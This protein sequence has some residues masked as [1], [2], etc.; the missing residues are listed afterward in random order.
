MMLTTE[1]R[2]R[3]LRPLLCLALAGLLAWAIP[4]TAS[5]PAP[6]P[7]PAPLLYVRFVTPFGGQVT[8][9]AGAPAGRRFD[10]PVTVGLR[11]GYIYR[12]QL[13][14]LPDRP[15]LALY[16]S[17]E[18]RGTLCLPATLRP[19]DYPA[20]IPISDQDI[21]LCLAGGVITKVIYLEDPAHALAVATQPNQPLETTLR[22]GADPAD[23]ARAFGRPM[24]IVRLGARTFSP[25]EMAHQSIPGTILL[26]GDAGL[27]APA[28][29]PCLPWAGVQLYD[30]I[31]GPRH[32]DDECLHDGGDSGAPAGLDQEGHLH[33]LDPSDTVAEYTDNHG[34]KHLAISNRVC[35][36]VPR[37]AILAV[38]LAPAGTVSSLAPARA[39]TVLA[40]EL[41]R[42]KQ[43]EIELRQAEKLVT[44][45]GRE[46]A[47]G[48][49]S[50]IGALPL[51]QSQGQAV[52]MGVLHEEVVIGTLEKKVCPPP[53][54][55]LVLCKTA[56]K[57]GVQVG[58][59][60]TFTLQFTNSGGQPIT[61]VVVS[62][63]LTGRLEYVPGSAQT[64]RPAIFTTQDNE[65]GSR[66][67]RWEIGGRLLPGESGVVRFQARVR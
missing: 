28:V 15:G 20:P 30:P 48:M 16:P 3:S 51:L 61:G 11:P 9:Y 60:V 31:L 29:R 14:R 33:G 5:L 4:A 49:E 26:P 41:L 57:Q 23:E 67:L 34:Q 44:L 18:V 19:A 59:V 42:V 21:A 65:A 36:C 12:V 62:D 47:S 8:V 32:C 37:F 40:Q 38:P 56:D 7:V 24:L 50:T 2:T 43:A 55:P 39:E 54:R 64:D 13:D 45:R 27:G 6:A 25:D 1:N 46:R 10:V 63:S 53:E 22:P 58:E 52:V 66:I 17:L 35:L